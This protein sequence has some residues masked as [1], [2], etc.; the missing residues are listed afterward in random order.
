MPRHK[1]A[2]GA[3]D[4]TL[5]KRARAKQQPIIQGTVKE[6]DRCIDVDVPSQRALFDRRPQSSA[7]AVAAQIEPAIAKRFGKLRIGLRFGDQRSG[8][9]GPGPD[10]AC[11]SGHTADPPARRQRRTAKDRGTDKARYRCPGGMASLLGID[12]LPIRTCHKS[13]AFDI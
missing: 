7:N 9:I 12:R 4:E 1:L 6:I 3:R 2:E 13:L 8:E 5:V 10:A 11:R